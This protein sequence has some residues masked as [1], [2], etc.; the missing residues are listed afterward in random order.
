MGD[1]FHIEQLRV[2]DKHFHSGDPYWD[3]D[4]TLWEAEISTPHSEPLRSLFVVPR[5]NAFITE[6]EVRRAI[7][8]L[9]VGLGP[10]DPVEALTHRATSPGPRRRPHILLA[11][12][13]G[14][15]LP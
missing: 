8:E 1:Q 7:D 9:L 13:P 5:A 12:E 6:P 4:Q 15:D 2:M 14:G 11:I 10:E 3:G